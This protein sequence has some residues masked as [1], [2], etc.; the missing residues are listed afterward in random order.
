MYYALKNLTCREV[1][2]LPAPWSWAGTVP[3]K[4]EWMNPEVDSCFVSAVEGINQNLRVSEKEDNAPHAIHAFIVDYDSPQDDETFAKIW[5]KDMA[6]PPFEVFPSW[7]CRTKSGNIRLLWEFEAPLVVPSV[8]A[9]QRMLKFATKYMRLDRWAPGLDK[10]AFESPNKYYAQGSWKQLSKHIIPKSLLEL[11]LFKGN[12]DHRMSG[13]TLKIPMPLLAEEAERRFPGQFKGRWEEGARCNVFWEQG[14]NPTSCIIH[15]DGVFAFSRDRFFGWAD[16]FGRDFCAKYEGD[17]IAQL[18]EQY[19]VDGKGDYWKQMPDGTWVSLSV[20]AISRELRCLGFDGRVPKGET[21]SEIDR[22]LQALL[23][24]GYVERALPFVHHKP[25]RLYYDGKWFL[26]ISNNA[27]MKPADIADVDPE[28][29]FPWIWNY[30]QGFFE[31]HEQLDYFLGWLK[32]FYENG[33]KQ[34]PQPGQAIVIAGPTSVGKTLLTQRIVGSMVGGFSDAEKF[35]VDNDTF[36]DVEVS[37]PLMAIDDQKA[38]VNGVTLSR[39]TTSVK[40]IV[41]SRELVFNGKYMARGKVRWLGRITI[42][43]NLDPHSLRILPDMDRSTQDKISLFKAAPHRP[44][45]PEHIKELDSIL[46]RE[47]P[48]FCAW[49]LKWSPPEHVIDRV[50]TRFRIKAYHHSDLMQTAKQGSLTATLGDI[51][52]RFLADQSEISGNKK[53]AWEGTATELYLALEAH[54]PS[55][56]RKVSP[57]YIGIELGRMIARGYNITRKNHKGRTVYELPAEI[58]GEIES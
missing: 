8:E 41:A 21:A 4:T 2:P 40:K 15:T 35:L 52:F 44:I 33:L 48:A 30:L 13:D 16:I 38:L 45:F 9:L 37:K 1:Q 42:T 10:A 17:R 12:Q 24:S 26:N 20:G 36:S 47:L 51:L 31:P 25:G 58:Q 29:D 19:V 50:D 39:F 14:E 22:V 34:A 6:K 49:L 27:C 55:V 5:A 56:M 18:R 11:M 54:A 23:V 32:H 43:C 28:H 46:D 3:D 53:I 57:Q 7:L